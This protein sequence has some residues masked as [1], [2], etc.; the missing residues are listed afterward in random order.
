MAWNPI[1][2]LFQ[3]FWIFGPVARNGK[4][5]ARF[6]IT[7]KDSQGTAKL[8]ADIG[9]RG[10]SLFSLGFEG[11]EQ[12]FQGR[13]KLFNPDSF[14]VEGPPPHLGNASLF[15]KCLFTIFAPLNPP[16]SNQQSDGSPL[17]FLLKGPQ[18][19]LRT[20]SQN[21]EQTLAKL[22]TNRIMNKRAFLKN[23]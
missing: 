20:L 12:T 1:F 18:T 17:E 22:R 19:E 23:W 6:K 13:N 11:G 9:S 8:P 3:L 4:R 10:Q 16:L 14:T 2:D 7:R 21:C 5:N 15:T